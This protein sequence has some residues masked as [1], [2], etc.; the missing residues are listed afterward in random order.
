MKLT[1]EEQAMLNVILNTYEVYD[2]DETSEK[3][4]K[5]LINLR[6]KLVK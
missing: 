6:K 4:N 5:I 1:T 2:D 3:E